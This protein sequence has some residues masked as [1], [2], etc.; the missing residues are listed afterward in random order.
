MPGIQSVF[1]AYFEVFIYFI[2][3]KEDAFGQ[4]AVKVDSLN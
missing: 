2:M 1:L 4:S 3:V